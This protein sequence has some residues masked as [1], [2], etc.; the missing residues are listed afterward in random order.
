[1]E[2]SRLISTTYKYLPEIVQLGTVILV[3]IFGYIGYQIYL[4]KKNIHKKLYFLKVTFPEISE[5]EVPK[6]KDK[7]RSVYSSIHKLINSQVDKFFI[8]VIKTQQYITVQVGC[9]DEK[10]LHKIK[11]LLSP[12]SNIQI[13]ETQEDSICSIKPLKGRIIT[14]T[15][16]FYPIAVNSNFTDGILHQLS[17][18]TSEQ[19]GLQIILRGVNKKE[20]I[21]SHITALE[22]RAKKYKRSLSESEKKEIEYYQN[23]LNSNLF[24]VKLVALG[25]SNQV[26]ESIVSLVH[27]LNHA[28]NVF[29]S[30]EIKNKSIVNRYIAPESPLTTINRKREGSYF[31][32]DELATIFS[33]SSIISGRYAPKQTRSFEATPEFME[34]T[35][36]NVQIGTIDHEDKKSPVFFP[37]KNFQRHIYVVGKTGRGKSTFLTSLISDLANKRTGSIFIFDPHGELLIDVMKVTG[38]VNKL[39]YFNIENTKSVFTFNPLFAFQKSNFEK[40]AIRDA[41]LDTVQ[42]ETQEIS[43]TQSGGVATYQRIKQVLEIGIDF[44]DAYYSWLTSKGVTTE[45][46]EVIVHKNQIT[47]NDLPLMLN[48]EMGYLP[49]LKA[50][51]KDGTSST[52][53]YVNKMLDKHVSNQMVVDAVQ[54]RLEQ[55]LHPSIRLICEGNRLNLDSMIFENK[56]FLFPIRE[57]IYGSRGARALIQSIFSL[58][59]LT[60]RK[61]ATSP[62]TYMFIDEFQKAQITSIPEI[63]AEGRKYKIYLTLSNQQLGQLREDVKNTILGNMGTLVS[64]TVSADDIGAGKLTPFFGKNMTVDDLSN[65]APYVAYLRT[66]GSKNKPLVT[67]SFRTIKPEFIEREQFNIETINQTTLSSYGELISDIENKISSKQSNP[68]KYFLEGI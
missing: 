49:V 24:K 58:L 65:L 18:L 4:H 40:A 41:L 5:H 28:T 15:K 11:G 20:Q 13:S 51:Y 36:T 6:Y 48:K 2:T 43:G 39:E 52:S 50:I 26:V 59:W 9:N 30:G 10:L 62:E 29:V 34:Q 35:D 38:D 8:E 14:T 22:Q 63:I 33:P 67:F 7:M 45:K 12:I 27:T 19:G 54:T 66:E 32:A 56:V 1:M 61:S 68:L 16:S 3:S 44:P 57:T 60:K 21:K 25:S 37:L 17:S 42:H 53:L 31:T 55:L 64:F 46:A 23:K 47:L